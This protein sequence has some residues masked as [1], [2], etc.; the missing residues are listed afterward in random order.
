MLALSAKYWL[1][2]HLLAVMWFCSTPRR[3]WSPRDALITCAML[4]RWP[5]MR[6]I[7][8]LPWRRWRRSLLLHQRFNRIFFDLNR[9]GLQILR[10]AQDD[11]I[12][13][14]PES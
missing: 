11:K 4:C 3:R 13:I 12:S 8:G 5:R 10:F 1:G 9:E 2:K 6:L 7:P 14:A